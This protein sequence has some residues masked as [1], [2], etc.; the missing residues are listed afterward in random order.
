MECPFFV[1]IQKID[2]PPFYDIKMRMF[3]KKIGLDRVTDVLSQAKLFLEC[4]PSGAGGT[5]SPPATPQRRTACK[6]QNGHQGAP[7]WPSGCGKMS[8]PLKERSKQLL[9]NKFFDPSTPSMREGCNRE[10]KNGGK[11]KD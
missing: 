9:L 7:K 1:A 11:R 5:R 10:K 6:I 8:L 3:A 2:D 4:H